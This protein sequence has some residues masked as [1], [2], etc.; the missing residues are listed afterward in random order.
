LLIEGLCVEGC[1]V[2]ESLTSMQSN[3]FR[4]IDSFLFSFEDFFQ[5]AATG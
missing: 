2:P 4:Q 5:S 1:G 3:I